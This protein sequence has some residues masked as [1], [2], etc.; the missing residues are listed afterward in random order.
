MIR[1]PRLFL[2]N[3]KFETRLRRVPVPPGRITDV[4]SY[5]SGSVW[6]LGN[7]NVTRRLKCQV[8]IA[9]VGIR[10]IDIPR[11][12]LV[13]DV[14]EPCPELNLLRFADLEV[15]EERDVKVASVWR[16]NV[17]RRL[18]RSGLTESRE[19]EVHRCRVPFRRPCR[20]LSADR[21]R[22]SAD[23]PGACRLVAIRVGSV[24]P[25]RRYR[26]CNI[27]SEAQTESECLTRR[28]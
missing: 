8:D 24:P 22:R 23:R 11:V 7:N 19:S 14:E 20:R 26:C 12:C 4:G 3:P 27:T 25:E 28:S 9:V 17:K 10:G 13:E 2:I 6:H 16:P 5:S 21:E 15:L 1:R 18:M